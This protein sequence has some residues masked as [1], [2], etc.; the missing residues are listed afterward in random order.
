ML[1]INLMALLAIAI[2]SGCSATGDDYIRGQTPIV[3]NHPV[4]GNLAVAER[5]LLGPDVN[6]NGIRDDIDVAIRELPDEKK[7]GIVNCV[8]DIT[9]GMI[10]GSRGIS[11]AAIE[12]SSTTL[13]SPPITD[14]DK[15]S[16]IELVTNTVPRKAAFDTWQDIKKWQ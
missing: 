10:F 15:I 1:K 8:K 14:A 2:L 5:E 11:S 16:Y 7:P 3:V 12:K 9:R 13:V 4:L 6:Q